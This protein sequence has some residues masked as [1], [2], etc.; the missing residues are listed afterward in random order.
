[1]PTTLPGPIRQTG[2]V[3][4][5]LQASVEAWRSLGIGP[6][7]TIRELT[8]RVRIRDIE[9]EPI[10]SIAFSNS[11]SLQIELIQQHNDAPSAYKEFT[12]HGRE[13]FHHIAFW[14]E[15][16]EDALASALS[17]GSKVMQEGNGGDTRFTYFDAGGVMS[18]ALEVCELNAQ[19]ITM[20]RMLA[21]AAAAW[22]GITDPV[23]LLM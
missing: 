15:D 20:N 17:A 22:D 7:Y 9:S 3:V 13:G 5:D 1:M 2:Y 14:A 6:W 10:I 12:D 19:N 11:G 16:Y 18:A 4:R 23:R 21:D 8:Q